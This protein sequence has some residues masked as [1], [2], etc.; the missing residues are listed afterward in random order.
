[1]RVRFGILKQVGRKYGRYDQLIPVFEKLIKE[2]DKF[3][4]KDLIKKYKYA[5]STDLKKPKKKK[6]L[7]VGTTNAQQLPPAV[8]SPSAVYITELQQESVKVEK[9]FTAQVD[10]KEEKLQVDVHLKAMEKAKPKKAHKKP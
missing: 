8:D 7:Q 1:M 5:F 6:M 4:E 9:S 3:L 2:H 10:L